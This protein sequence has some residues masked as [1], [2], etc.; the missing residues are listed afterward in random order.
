[1]SARASVKADGSLGTG[2][3]RLELRLCMT[4][5]IADDTC[6]N[7]FLSRNLQC[8]EIWTDLDMLDLCYLSGCI[9]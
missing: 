6:A 2:I 8:Q 7:D 9:N 5:E 4:C 1:M 3:A